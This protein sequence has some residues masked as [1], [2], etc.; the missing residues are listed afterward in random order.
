MKSP[1]LPS[2]WRALPHQHA[3][4]SRT[5][6]RPKETPVQ[7]EVQGAHAHMC[8]CAP[9]CICPHRKTGSVFAREAVP[10]PNI[11]P[12]FPLRD[13]KLLLVNTVEQMTSIEQLISKD[14]QLLQHSRASLPETCPPP[15]YC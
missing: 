2:P 12:R 8:M 7:Q 9:T 6:P 3:P 13:P 5:V 4:G 15:I 10:C 1:A 14:I 11:L